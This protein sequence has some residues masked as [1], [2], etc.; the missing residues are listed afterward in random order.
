MSS[1]GA[2]PV[3]GLV[4]HLF[5]RESARL[6]AALTHILGSKRLD[7]AEEVVQDAIVRA[8]ETWP[9]RGVPDDPGAWL[10]RTARNRAIDVLRRESAL[11]DKLAGWDPQA[12]QPA[13]AAAMDDE[14]A[15]IFLCCHPAL[16]RTARVALT[17]KTV[18]GFGVTEIARAFLAQPET[19]AQRLV[20]AKRTLRDSGAEL[21]LPAASALRERLGSVHDVLYLMFNEGYAAA[22]G[23]SLVRSELC[24]EA[25]RLAKLIAASPV[26]ASPE[27]DALLAL[28]YLQGSRLSARMD[29]KGTLLLLDEQDRSVWDAAMIAEGLRLMDRSARGDRVTRYHLEAG[30]AACH[31]V[32]PRF[33]DTNWV[34]IEDLYMQLQALNDS[35]VIALNRA[36]AIGMTRG[37]TWALAFLDR[38]ADDPAM[39]R[40]VLYHATI[41]ELLR[42]DGEWAR[43]ADAFQRALELPASEPERAFLRRRLAACDKR[44]ETR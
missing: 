7:L 12:T 9:H 21:S 28:M 6:V 10:A 3:R 25:I 27:G 38:Y 31:A 16:T 43:A 26:T 39:Q 15:M 24:S 20:R 36:V 29:E 35:S 32:A 42:R 8:L 33:E 23:A 40:Y 30:I 1:D 17:L 22:S 19:I 34:R 11:R 44:G 14:L 41:G 2:S 13:R 18:G 4:E 37:S 5:R